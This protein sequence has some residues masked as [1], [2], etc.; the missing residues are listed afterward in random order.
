MLFLID[1]VIIMAFVY[2]S[3]TIFCNE[4]VPTQDGY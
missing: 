4:V 2:K 1:V 3:T